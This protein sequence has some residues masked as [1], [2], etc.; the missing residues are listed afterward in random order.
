MIDTCGPQIAAWREAVEESNQKNQQPAGGG[1]S[2]FDWHDTPLFPARPQD[3]AESTDSRI[4]F[5]DSADAGGTSD[6]ADSATT[7]FERAG[8]FA[9][10]VHL[11]D[12]IVERDAQWRKLV[13]RGSMRYSEKLNSQ[14]VEAYGLWIQVAEAILSEVG[15]CTDEE[16][17]A[18]Q[19]DTLRNWLPEMRNKLATWTPPQI[20]PAIGLRDQQMSESEAA[21]FD[22]MIAGAAQTP[23]A[24]QKHAVNVLPASEF[25]RR[26][27]Q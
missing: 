12:L 3:V 11:H 5:P 26:L 21:E 25:A 4:D 8:L 7:G 10:G 22:R 14:F 20:S 24:S 9:V 16:S 2:R 1:R 17:A 18:A 6:E 27:K 13:F 23:Y 15:Q 19:A